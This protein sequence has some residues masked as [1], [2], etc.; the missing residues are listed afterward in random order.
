MRRTY[1]ALILLGF[2]AISCDLQ[3]NPQDSP[4]PDQV[5]ST[6]A[7]LEKYANSFYKMLPSASTITH[8]DDNVSD[9]TSQKNVP[10]L[11]RGVV[12]A[13]TVGRWGWGNLR[14]INYFIQHNHSSKIPKDTRENYSGIARFYRAWFYYKKVKK[15]GGVPWI[16]KVLDY[17][18]KKLQ[19]KRD[20]R[21]LVMDSVLADIDYAIE[22]IKINNES[23]RTEITRD[24]ALALKSR[25]TL[26][27]GTYRKY[28]HELGLESTA[29]KW[30]KECVS[31]SKKL[32]DSGIYS[33][34][35]GDG[36]DNS[37]RKL[38]TSDKPI[39]SSVILADVYSTDLG[40]T[41]D[42]NW[43]YTS[44]TYGVGLSFNRQFINTYLMRNGTPFT[45]QN[46]YKTMTYREEVKNRDTRLEQT[47]RMPDLKRISSSGS[48]VAAP[49]NFS[50]TFSGYQPRKWTVPDKHFDDRDYNV[51]AVPIFRYAEVL[52]NYAE[53]KAELH[54]ITD[55][56]WDKTVGALRRRAGITGGT[57]T[58]PTKVDSYL[59]K[60]FF[61][62]I[63]DPV[64][65]EIRRDRGIELTLENFRFDDLRRWKRGKL[66]EMEW[67]GIYVPNANTY[68]DLTGDGKPDVY[69]Y[70]D[71]KPTSTKGGVQYVNVGGDELILSNGNSGYLIR[72]PNATREW[73]QKYYLYPINTKDLQ[74]NKKLEQNPGW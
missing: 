8:G 39:A 50:Y 72:L 55:E 65:L 5:F 17:N 36:T 16:G 71:S 18:L 52:L 51:N 37:Y 48:K 12:N 33:V 63:S 47:I 68:M 42:A 19:I 7:G 40:R 53:A 25:I 66:T 1:L 57:N 70:T 64:I 29:K 30:L 62:N 58:L 73:K 44:G 45:D 21:T 34:Y 32:M 35:N 28:H 56:D 38:F 74:R 46:N 6:K 67:K 14:N 69:F 54:T 60:T 20:P 61:P 24:V 22:H 59:Q 11:L 3:E 31:A 15:Y 26:F 41:H 23:S 2:I 49:P 13:R 43:W 4:A 27:E 10:S 9:Y